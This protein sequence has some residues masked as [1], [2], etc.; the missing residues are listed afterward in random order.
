MMLMSCGALSLLVPQ[1]KSDLNRHFPIFTIMKL[2]ELT[3]TNFRSFE[4]LELKLGQQITLLLGENGSGKSSILD[5]IG[6]GLGVIPSIVS[7]VKGISFKKTDLRQLNNK[8]EPFVR[9][10]LHSNLGFSW[11]RLLRRDN[12]LTRSKQLPASTGHVALKHYLKE[13]VSNEMAVHD[14]DADIPVFAHYGVNRA[15]LNAPLSRKGFSKSYSR[16]DAYQGALEATSNFRSAFKW[17]YHRETEEL[18]Q[19]RENRDFDYT[20]PE[21]EAVRQAIKKTFPGIEKPRIKTNPLRFVVDFGGETLSIDQLGD[22][23]KTMLALVIDLAHRMAI[24]N[25]HRYQPLET[26]A[27]VLIDEIDLHLHPEW[28]TRVISDLINVFPNTQFVLTTHSPFIVESL[29]NHLISHQVNYKS[30]SLIQNIK[31]YQPIKP[32][33][34]TAYQVGK[35]KAVNMLD[36]NKLLSNSLLEVYNTITSD[37]VNMLEH[38]SENDD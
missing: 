35:G 33:D 31:Y 16:F 12:K 23:Y 19:Q 9:V 8:E 25:P 36:D 5:A 37:F 15:L 18:R 3:L 11:D 17:F 26:K 22:G 38:S 13:F 32:S 2:T 34:I 28:Q 20:L 10:S 1:E 27:I 6:V 4:K 30:A 29:N 21:L 7:N 14:L 24:A